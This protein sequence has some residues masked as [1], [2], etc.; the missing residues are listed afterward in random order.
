MFLMQAFVFFHTTVHRLITPILQGISH[1]IAP[2]VCRVCGCTLTA[3]EKY[4][5][6]GCEADLPRC[7]QHK[8]PF[9]EIHRRLGHRVAV[10]R[11]AGWFYY[12]KGS[13]FAQLLVDAKYAQLPALAVELG[14]KCA[15]EFQ[16]EGFFNGIDVIVPMPMHWWKEIRRGYNQAYEICRGISS[17]TGLPVEKAIKAVKPHGVQSRHTLQKRFDRIHDTMQPSDN[18]VVADKHVLLVD[19]IITTGASCSEALRALSLAKPSKI[20]VLCLGLTMRQ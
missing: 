18:T 16:T 5:C 10:E 13:P 4:I 14:R 15:L 9:N 17:V 2:R 3:A 7:N 20:S 11:G 6:L 8:S 1:L 12:K 19:D